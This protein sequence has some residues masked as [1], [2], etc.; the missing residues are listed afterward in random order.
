[1]Y[2]VLRSKINA[3]LFVS[4]VY[5]I[6]WSLLVIFFPSI[7]NSVIVEKGNTPIIFWDFMSLIT[8][9]LGI[10]LMIAAS[11]PY[12]HWPIIVLVTLFHLA[13]IAGFVFG[14]QIGFFNTLY[15]KFILM[16]HI[17]W[18]IP[19]AIVLYLVYR[20]S[21]D[22]DDMLIDTFSNDQYP[23]SLFDT[24]KGENLG[25]LNEE[26]PLMLVFLRHFGCP[27]CK[28]SLLELAAHRAEL[29]SRGIKIVLVYMVDSKTAE[30]YLDT[31]GLNDL[32]Q[33]SDPEEIF[34]KSF[35]LKRG[36]FIQLFGA[37]VWIRWV[38]LAF[39]KKLFNTKP[40]GNVS[41]MPGIFLVED[42]VVKKQFVHKS[43]ADT[44]DYTLFLD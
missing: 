17:I 24:T 40:E 37:K 34:Y 39:S 16:N 32:P 22:T 2:S 25:E 21:F 38:E 10:G 18:L 41:Q 30:H 33:V 35:R 29:E 5:F 9:V 11:N 19:N 20:R 7:I 14:Y 28:D 1:M 8:F 36:N 26:A 31:Y 13:M 3:S 15:L 43:V 12:R 4:A 27:F 23:L 42:G 44:P 6:I